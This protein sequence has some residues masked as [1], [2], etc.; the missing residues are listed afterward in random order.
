[1][2][3]TVYEEAQVV[4]ADG[5]ASSPFNPPKPQIRH[6]F[7][8]TADAIQSASIG[9]V[10]QATWTSLSNITG[11]AAGQPARV[12]GPDAG[13]H[14]DPV[15]GGTVK[16]IGEYIWSASPAGWRRTGGL[17][18]ELVYATNTNSGTANAIVATA[19]GALDSSPGKTLIVID[20]V[21]SNGPGGMTLDIDGDVRPLV[22][23]TGQPIP[24]GYVQPGMSALVQVDGDGN[25][26]LFSYGD[27][28]AIQAA[29]EAAL[30]AAA[31]EADRSTSNADRAETFAAMLSVDKIKFKFVAALDADEMLSY[32]AGDDLIV[33]GPGD[34]I[35]AGGH[36][37]SVS[38]DDATDHHVTT[39]GGVKL[40]MLPADS[41]FSFGALDVSTDATQD[42]SAAMWALAGF[43]DDERWSS[44]CVPT[45][46]RDYLIDATVTITNPVTLVG[47]M[48]ATYHRG[49]GKAGSLLV[50]ENAT[51]AFD[52][53]NSRTTGNPADNWSVSRIGV[54]QAA[55][56]TAYTKDGFR[57]TSKTDGPDR[58]AVFREVSGRGLNAAIR[59]MDP[60]VSTAV[61]NLIIENSVLIANNY[62]VL[63]EGSVLGL[64]FVGNQAE[65]N[66]LGAI[67]GTF[68]AGV[69]IEDNML[70]GQPNPI[71]LKG[72][73]I[74]G[75]RLA[76]GHY[77]NY[78]EAVSGDY[79]V[80]LQSVASDSLF[81]SGGNY[82]VGTHP[83]DDYVIT[84]GGGWE[85]DIHESNQYNGLTFD[86]FVGSV[87]RGSRFIHN[88][89]YK[90]RKNTALGNKWLSDLV[91]L[92]SA[93]GDYT[94]AV[95]ASGETRQTIFGGLVFSTGQT[96]IAI[97][98]AVTAGDL[99]SIDLLCHA[100][101][102]FTA[103]SV[104]VYNNNQTVIVAEQGSVAFTAGPLAVCAFD[105]VA[106]SSASSLNFRVF[107]APS[108]FG[109]TGVSARNYG[110]HTNDGSAAKQIFP[111]CPP[112]KRA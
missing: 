88:G 19:D 49:V 4:Y 18:R 46:G 33:V 71:N 17:D 16:N 94:S 26:R 83:K 81:R 48:G 42:S 14:T 55:G 87:R 56:V 20:F 29:A 54:K 99:V 11:T 27:A 41:G 1:M 51:A 31:N 57:L 84:G 40:H 103:T 98:M 45:A 5:P 24:V 74:T 91:T 3:N 61:A 64:R 73:S 30:A 92:P 50:G 85:L 76:V 36:R 9:R 97:P 106:G 10:D 38:P 101:A 28:T 95:P 109:I 80:K 108:T 21:A 86:S 37:F 35:E 68:T 102:A 63:A 100:P 58:A 96:F 93:T 90:V 72:Y 89:Y 52:L 12:V 110:A 65:Q 8:T 34:V 60:G 66:V 105:F 75:N 25:Y 43:A 22:T 47:N 82:F 111:V 23:N 107:G 77:R 44:I 67:H 112:P 79:I 70:E 7:K 13:A 39:D 2:S 78:Y 6:L 15:V 69:A 53:G 32:V 62:A 104:Q 59:V